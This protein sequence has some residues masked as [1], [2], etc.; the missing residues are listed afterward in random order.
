MLRRSSRRAQLARRA[1][2]AEAVAAGA[3]GAAGGRYGG[4][5]GGRSWRMQSLRRQVLQRWWLE[6]ALLQHMQMLFSKKPAT[7]IPSKLQHN[8]RLNLSSTV[9]RPNLTNQKPSKW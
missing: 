5:R 3:T 4:S 9:H 7:Q 8:S 6:Q 2:A 1:D